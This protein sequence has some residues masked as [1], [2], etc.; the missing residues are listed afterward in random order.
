[1]PESAPAAEPSKP[2]HRWYH[3][4]SA[5]LFANFCFLL[6]VVLTVFPW[7][8]WWDGNYFSDFNAEWR[9]IWLNPYFRGAVSGIGLLNV[10]ISFAEIFRL[11]R[12][13]E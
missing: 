4:L 9:R 2:V 5:L 6:G 1:M 7:L 3:K 12:F 10:Y 13:S 11:R 8:N